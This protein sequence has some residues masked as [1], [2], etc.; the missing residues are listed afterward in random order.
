MSTERED[1]CKTVRDFLAKERGGE[2]TSL[3]KSVF[4]C[5][6][7]GFGFGNGENFRDLN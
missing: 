4:F 2:V 3:D 5:A 6:H 1:L 7:Q